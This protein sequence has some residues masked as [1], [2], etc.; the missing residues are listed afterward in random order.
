MIQKLSFLFLFMSLLPTVIFAQDGTLKGKI[1]DAS[2]AEPVFG[3]TVVVRALKKGARTDFDGKYSLDLP[4]GSHSVEYIMMGFD[5]QVKNITINAGQT[6][7]QNITFGAKALDVVEVKGRAV[8]NT[9]AS[10]LQAQRKSGSVS[11]GISAESIKKSPDS[12]AGEVIKRV[13]GV[14]LIGGKYVFVRGLGER[15]SNTLLDDMSIPSTEPDKRVIPL[16]LFPAGAI[17]NL[18]IVK[19][20]VPEDPAEFSGGIVKIE[21][22]EYPDEFMMSL[23]LGLGR[24]YNTTGNEFLTFK[25]GGQKNAFGMVGDKQKLPDMVKSFPDFMPFRPGDAFGGIPPQLINMT[26]SSFD[27]QWTPDK[28]DAPFDRNFNFSV[29]NTI[30]TEKYGRFGFMAGTSYNRN[31]RFRREKLKR[32]VGRQIIPFVKETT[33]LDTLQTQDIN[34]Y[35]EEVLWGNNLNLSY[36]PVDGQQFFSKTLYTIQSDKFV[37]DADGY[38]GIDNFLF[39]NQTLGFTSRTLMSNTFGGKN[40]I[41][42]GEMGRPHI[43]DWAFNYSDANRDEPDLRN[44]LWQRTETAYDRPYTKSGNRPDGTRFFSESDDIMKSLSLKY[45]IPFKQW[46]GLYSKAKVGYLSSSRYKNFRFREFI[47]RRFVGSDNDV[48]FPVP[49]ELLYNPLVFLN[50]DRTFTERAEE[51][52]AYDAIHKINAY[53]AQVD[54]PLVPNVRFVGGARYE[55]SYQK[56]KTFALKDTLNGT[57]LDYGCK[58]SND[59]ERSALIQTGICR[60]DNNGVGEL[61]TQDTL[62]SLNFVWEFKKDQNLRWA[63]T[64]TLTRPDL[65]ELSPFGFSPYFGANLVYG[66][67]SLQRSYIHNYDFRYEWYIKGADFVGA[68]LFLKQ[69]SNPIEIVGQPLAGSPGFVYTYT[70]ARE[71]YIRGLEL[72]G[73]KDFFDK[74]R[75]ETNFF[76]IKSRVEVM[77][78]SQY[79]AVK[80]GLVGTSSKL[81]SYDPTNRVRPLQGQSDFVYNVKFLYFID[82]KKNTSIGL[83]YNYFGDRISVVGASN[84]PDAYEKGVGVTDIVF[85][86]KQGKHLDIK[87]AAKNIMDTRFRTYQ[88]NELMGTNDLFGSYREGVTFTAS[89]TYKF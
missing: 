69:L 26:T 55:D 65:R 1:I 47:Q 30:K 60:P 10:L 16:D 27:S 76:F 46:D 17:K 49:G 12:S 11:D 6:T 42:I 32:Y 15:Y 20:F 19:T 33:Y 8:N 82:T 67:S 63:Y 62:P 57:N 83:Y 64:E 24:N 13:T 3:V 29:G 73:R 71:A 5:T 37:R 34:Q 35:N 61:R 58:Y 23:G 48:P 41:N 4:A 70:N 54:M 87:L 89:A 86:H 25:G 31:F 44:Q 40:A 53:F 80:L 77:D 66:N 38:N 88:R 51:S 84:A 85:Q 43:L 9:E 21:T 36:E 45:E 7:T 50:G 2:N 72:D 14:T 68:G 28:M 39:K 22:K 18:R 79:T 56:V 74:F 59:Y 75:I 52:N 78:D 81:F